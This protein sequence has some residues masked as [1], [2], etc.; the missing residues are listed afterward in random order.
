M[1]TNTAKL[2][3]FSFV[4]LLAICSC[5]VFVD[6]SI[7]DT[8]GAPPTTTE[9]FIMGNTTATVNISSGT[10]FRF[11]IGE[12][13]EN[14]VKDLANKVSWVG[15]TTSKVTYNHPQW[16]MMTAWFVNGTATP[17]TYT[18]TNSQLNIN[19]TIVVTTY[20][21]YKVQGESDAE[22]TYSS[23]TVQLRNHNSATDHQFR[24]F[25]DS[26]YTQLVGNA[27]Q[28]ASISSSTTLYG[29][30]IQTKVTLEKAS[31]NVYVHYRDTETYKVKTTPSDVKITP[32]WSSDISQ[33]FSWNGSD[34]TFTDVN[35]PSGIYA[36]S[37]TVEKTGMNPSTMILYINVYPNDI[38]NLTFSTLGAW[39]YTIPTYNALDGA[40]ILSA[41]RTLDDQ[42]YS[43]PVSG[44]TVTSDTRKISYTFT[45]EGVY[46]FVV[47]LLSPQA[48]NMGSVHCTAIIRVDVQDKIE[49]GTPLC[50]GISVSKNGRLYDFTLLNPQNY[51]SIIWDFGDYSS[52]M[53]SSITR[54]HNYAFPGIYKVT[55]TLVNSDGETTQVSVLIDAMEVGMPDSLLRY[56][57]YY[58]SVIVVAASVSDITVNCPDWMSWEFIQSSSTSYVAVRGS[59]TDA[60]LVGD[61]VTIEIYS[62]GTLVKSQKVELLKGYSDAHYSDFEYELDGNSIRIKFT[63]TRDKS[64]VI[65]VEWYAGAGQTLYRERA[66]GW[67]YHTYKQS[68]PITLT[69]SALS[70]GVNNSSERN[71][72]ISAT[73]GNGDGNSHDDRD[74]DDTK[75]LAVIGLAIIIA[76]LAVAT[77]LVGRYGLTAILAGVGF[78]IAFFGGI[79]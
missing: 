41:T 75:S 70:G 42:T 55:A 39:S 26:G 23:S 13:G 61:T 15:G 12:S 51:V 34:I 65:S 30:N 63:G 45:E 58:G 60:E 17:G 48:G 11:L 28:N 5:A 53:S 67:M 32:Q 74:L 10:S 29:K 2:L 33:P 14:V 6:N 54:P 24:W 7:E 43:V 52:E 35:L 18:Y 57:V 77:M 16:G 66:D 40:K 68:G 46:E 9:H 59:F 25:K 56:Q 1:K 73:P 71:F 44:I 47:Q 22:Q 49:S 20:I 19:L 50:D 72:T 79:I 62:Q 69:V 78:L 21:T 31:D 3:S 8:E 76:I 64:T 37:V 36:M 27:G 38:M 4:V